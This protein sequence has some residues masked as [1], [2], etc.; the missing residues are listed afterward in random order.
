MTLGARLSHPLNEVLRH[1]RDYTVTAT[2]QLGA[3]ARGWL[4][5]VIPDCAVLDSLIP[6]FVDGPR[7]V[8][9]W[10]PVEQRKEAPAVDPMLLV[11][12]ALSGGVTALARDLPLRGDLKADPRQIVATGVRRGLSMLATE[13]RQQSELLGRF[14]AEL[15]SD[16][17]GAARR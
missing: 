12:A 10:E 16:A 15:G 6:H 14:A 9:P 7:V 2:M 3:W 4:L 11:D 8:M 1:D 5:R 17:A 13:M